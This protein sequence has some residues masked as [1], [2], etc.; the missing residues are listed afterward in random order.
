ML[1]GLC[2]LVGNLT[3]GR[4]SNLLGRRQALLLAL[5][6]GTL[7][8]GCLTVGRGATALYVASAGFGFYYGAYASLFPAVMGD[9][10][11]R[12]HAGALTGL[13]FALGSITSAV[14]PVA[15]GWA[16]DRT[17][18]YARAFLCST[19]VNGLV[20]IL[21]ALARPPA[22]RSRATEA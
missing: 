22:R 15:M 8:L 2:A 3:L 5:I 16:A 1:V 11:G 6:V 13:S 10:F 9:F 19:F 7:A 21:L 14:G 12:L 17:G 18:H 4:L 20:I